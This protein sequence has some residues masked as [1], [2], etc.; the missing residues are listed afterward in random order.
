MRTQNK[1]QRRSGFTLVELVVV[2]LIIGIL[3]AAAAPK[4]FDTANEAKDS[5]AEQSLS[6]IRDA[7]ELYKAENGSYPGT[8]EATFKAGLDTFLR[9]KSFP[10]CPV[11]NKD[12]TVRV[13]TS[14]AALTVS[15]TQSWAYDN[16]TGELI[17]NFTGYDNL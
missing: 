6:V 3:A 17:I 12:D 11:G 8:D 5:S 15:G 7:I 16:L 10:T 13:Q 4:M 14:G 1:Q 2:V 9:G